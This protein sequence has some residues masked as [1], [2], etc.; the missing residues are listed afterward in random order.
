MPLV[1]VVVSLGLGLGLEGVGSVDDVVRDRVRRR[2]GGAG[3]C[4]IVEAAMVDS[5]WVMKTSRSIR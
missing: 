5:G 2:D 3:D 1:V 4:F